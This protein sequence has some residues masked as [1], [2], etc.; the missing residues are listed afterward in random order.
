MLGWITS[1]YCMCAC[2]RVTIREDFSLGMADMVRCNIACTCR[3]GEQ[4]QEQHVWTES[5]WQARAKCSSGHAS[6]PRRPECPPA[7]LPPC[8]APHTRARSSSKTFWMPWTGWTR[9][10]PSPRTRC[11]AC[12]NML[13][14]S[15]VADVCCGQEAQCGGRGARPPFWHSDCATS[16]CSQG[17]CF[18]LVFQQRRHCACVPATKPSVTLP[19]EHPCCRSQVEA[20]AQR[21][22]DRRLSRL[23]TSIYKSIRDPTK[24]AVRPC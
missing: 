13:R 15:Y 16:C 1:P 17:T 4:W 2:R 3:D 9:T 5:Q 19:L 14:Q 22:M 11:E 10:S 6:G 8:A 24:K 12:N 7:C 23:D 18:T 21:A 20:L